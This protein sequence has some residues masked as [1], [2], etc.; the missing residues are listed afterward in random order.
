L[1]EFENLFDLKFQKLQL[2]FLKKV[3]LLHFGPTFLLFSF[4]PAQPTPV[5][6]AQPSLGLPPQPASNNSACSLHPGPLRY[7]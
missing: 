7:T 4:F 2:K 5:D 3:P 1:F 6:L